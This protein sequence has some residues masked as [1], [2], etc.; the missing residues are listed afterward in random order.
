MNLGVAYLHLSETA[1]ALNHLDH[2]LAIARETGNLRREGDVYEN[3]V[4]KHVNYGT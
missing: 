2:A 1:L 3:L 4:L